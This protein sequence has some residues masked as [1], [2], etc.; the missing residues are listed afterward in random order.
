MSTSAQT[1]RHSLPTGEEIVQTLPWRWRAQGRIFL[2]GGLGFMFDAWDVSLNGVL[3]PLLTAEWDITAAD[4]ALIGTANLIGMAVGAVLWGTIADRIGRKQAFAWTLL[5]FS[6]FTIAG[7]A[8]NTLEWFLLFRFL[9]GV[10]LGGCIPVDYALVSEFTPAKHRGRVLTA[11]DIW[12]PIGAACAFFVS[13]GLLAVW[14][15]WQLPLLA[16][17]LP[18]LLVFAVRLWVPESPLYLIRQGREAE[19]RKVIDDLVVRT[20]AAPRDYRIDTTTAGRPMS[21]RAVWEQLRAVWTHSWRITTVSWV[22]FLAIMTVYYIAL[23][24]MPTLLI[25][26]GYEESQ[27]FIRTAGMAA[28]GILGVIISTA[29]VEF[30]GRR[31]LLAISAPASAALLVVLGWNMHLPGAVLGLLL[32]FGLVVQIAIPVLYAYVSELYPTALR[33]SGFGWA[34]TI[35]RVGA[36]LGPLVFITWMEPALGLAGAFAV[37]LAAVVA[38]VVVM[39]ALAPDTTSR[40]LR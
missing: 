5:I 16:M 10:G 38:A 12:W 36:G 6:I 2:I 13:A 11:M 31:Y 3:I 33:G 40:H 23:Q 39:M 22:L 34:S 25:E 1:A 27:S 18:A 32:G 14:S 29:L 9:A 19:A 30:T 26:A 37:C 8:T 28:V 7:A 20:G 35:S 4:A 15:A 17:I 21:Y 24:W